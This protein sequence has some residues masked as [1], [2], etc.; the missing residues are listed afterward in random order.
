MRTKSRPLRTRERAGALTR[1]GL[2]GLRTAKILLEQVPDRRPRPHEQ[3]L[4]RR[5]R[6]PERSRDLLPRVARQ[7]VHHKRCTL[8]KRKLPDRTKHVSDLGAV[9]LP[10]ARKV[11]YELN[12]QRATRPLPKPLPTHIT[13][14][15]DQPA[16]RIPDTLTLPQDAIRMHERRLGRVL[17]VTEITEHRQRVPMHRISVIAIQTLE[18][19]LQLRPSWNRDRHDTS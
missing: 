19:P 3:H 10:S 14:D 17:C 11:G 2:L 4:H 8:P 18:R 15:R 12:L 16:T 6:H 5:S 1:H 13:G 7:L 9:I